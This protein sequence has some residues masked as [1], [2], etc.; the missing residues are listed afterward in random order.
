MPIGEPLVATL[1]SLGRP[2]SLR[3]SAKMSFHGT[4]DVVLR[5]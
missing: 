4:R 5:A 1:L 2:A 3:T